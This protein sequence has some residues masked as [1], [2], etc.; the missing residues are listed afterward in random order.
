MFV[1]SRFQIIRSR[2][3]IFYPKTELE[4]YSE[5]SIFENLDVENIIQSLQEDGLYLGIQLPQTIVEEIL[6]FTEREQ[7]YANLNPQLMFHVNSKESWQ[8]KYGSLVVSDYVDPERNCRAIEKIIQ[9]PKL[10]KIAATYLNAKPVFT[11][12]RLWWSF[13]TNANFQERLNF[14]QELFHYDPTDYRSLKFFFYLTN[15]GSGNGPHV[16]VRGSHK[17]K[18]ISHQLTLFI[19]RS[20]RDISQYYQQKDILTICGDVGFGFA[21]DPFCFHKGTPPQQGDRLM[22][23]IEFCLNNYHF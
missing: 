2:I 8:E 11:G 6:E 13:A 18:K 22:L 23:Q 1:F 12:S 14:A 21:E 3:D 15:V 20:D 4:Q 16:C 17:N 7:C 5:V 19:G 9:D 10:L